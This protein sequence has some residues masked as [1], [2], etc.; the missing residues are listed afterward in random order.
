MVYIGININMIKT[1]MIFLLLGSAIVE[2]KERWTFVERTGP[3]MVKSE[4]Y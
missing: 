4:N 3:K 1:N 2:R